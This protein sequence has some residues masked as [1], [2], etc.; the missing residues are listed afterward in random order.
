MSLFRLLPSVLLGALLW[1]VLAVAASV[2]VETA[3]GLLEVI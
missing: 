2:L 3:R 1:A